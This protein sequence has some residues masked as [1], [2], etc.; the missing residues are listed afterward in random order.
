MEYLTD[1]LEKLGIRDKK[2]DILI[3]MINK[4]KSNWKAEKDWEVIDHKLNVTAEE[5]Y[6]VKH[7]LD[8]MVISQR[9]KNNN[10]LYVE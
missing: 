10:K 9:D 8:G 2:K 6:R 5:V 3:G 1:S 7:D 4:Y